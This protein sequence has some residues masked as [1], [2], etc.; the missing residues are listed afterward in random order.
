ML[1]FNDIIELEDFEF[2]NILIDRKSHENAL[3]YDISYKPLIDP[4]PLR[5][6]FNKVDGYIKIY[7]RTRYLTWINIIRYYKSKKSH[8]MYFFSLFYKNQS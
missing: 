5:I 8:Y 3:I 7:D 6:R 1:L 2:N 4:K